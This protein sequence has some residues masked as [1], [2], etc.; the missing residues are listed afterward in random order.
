MKKILVFLTVFSFLVSSQAFAEVYQIDKDHSSVSFKIKHLFSKV[1]GHFK[2]YESSFTYEPGKPETWNAKAVIK[3][4]SIDT[5]V[6]KRDEHLKSPDFFDVATY[7]T[8]EFTSTGA[9]EASDNKGKLNGVLK[10]HGVEKP[11]TLD[12]EVHGV[13][14]DPWGNTRLGATATTTVNRKDFG[15]TWNKA[16][17]TGQLLVGEDV[18][19]TLEI[20]GIQQKDVA[21]AE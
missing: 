11:V 7:P 17:E 10:M 16:L 5:G 15:L 20:E 18:E 14:N 8:I 6:E 4:D 13:G 21:N 19:I 1:Q 12:L 2:D 3:T 9:S